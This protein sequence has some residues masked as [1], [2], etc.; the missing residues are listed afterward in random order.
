MYYAYNSTT[1]RNRDTVL[2]DI[3]T[4]IVYQTITENILSYSNPIYYDYEQQL[5]S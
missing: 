1:Q 5:Y 4:A 3:H 2:Y